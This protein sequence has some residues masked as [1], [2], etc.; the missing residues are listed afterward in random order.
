[1]RKAVPVGLS[2]VRIVDAQLEGGLVTNVD[3]AFIATA[4]VS[5]LV[6]TGASAAMILH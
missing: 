4:V 1:M 5:M 2:T 3:L 6:L